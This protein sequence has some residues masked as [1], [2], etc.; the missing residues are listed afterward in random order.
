MFKLF[1]YFSRGQK[2]GLV[3]LAAVLV[4]LIVA[5]GLVAQFVESPKTENDKDFIAKYEAFK[6]SLKDKPLH[7][8]QYSPFNEK[9]KNYDNFSKFP[10]PKFF[11]FNPNTLDSAN[12]VKLGLKPFI[13]KNILNYR[14]KGAKFRTAD[15]FSKIY[16]ISVEQFESLKPFIDIP[17]EFLSEN[18]DKIDA[19]TTDKS[20][21]IHIELNSADTADLKKL[22][23]IGSGWAKAIV[24]YRQKLGGYVDVNQLLEIKNFPPETFS[25][26]EQNLYINDENVRKIEINRANVDFMRSHPY[27]NFY[28]AKAIYHLRLDKKALK[29]IDELSILPEFNAVELKKIAPYFDF[30]EIKR[31]YK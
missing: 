21:T 7:Y 1:L 18:I 3:V 24:A 9:G 29:S 27:L 31:N 2:I 17:S 8:Q 20:A 5:N 22:Q 14:K 26:I 23:G 10:E 15:D 19:K 30:K 4:I 13:V 28:K 25:K 16:G 6:N 12:F 11:T